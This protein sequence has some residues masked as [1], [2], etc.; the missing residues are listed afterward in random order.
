MTLDGDMPHIKVLVL[1][2][3][4]IIFIKKIM[5]Y[6]IY[7]EAIPKACVFIKLLIME[8]PMTRGPCIFII[9]LNLL[10]SKHA[11]CNGKKKLPNI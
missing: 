11:Y 1:D 7:F 4:M 9:E 8:K 10:T 2:C 5:I 3:L 6:A